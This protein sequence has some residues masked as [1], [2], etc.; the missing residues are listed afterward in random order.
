MQLG[1]KISISV[2]GDGWTDLDQLHL[3]PFIEGNRIEGSG[4]SQASTPL[5]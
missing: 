4:K 3:N 2:C 1:A 5:P